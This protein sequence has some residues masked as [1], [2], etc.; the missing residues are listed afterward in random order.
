MADYRQGSHDA[1]CVRFTV[2]CECPGDGKCAVRARGDDDLVSAL[3]VNTGEIVVC[4]LDAVRH[5]L[6]L[7]LVAGLHIYGNIGS[8]AAEDVHARRVDMDILAGAHRIINGVRKVRGLGE[9]AVGEHIGRVERALISCAF[10]GKC[11]AAD[12]QCQPEGKSEH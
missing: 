7:V 11:R 9:V 5:E 10:R 6:D 2:R 4:D 12:H 8:A 1:V 3:Y